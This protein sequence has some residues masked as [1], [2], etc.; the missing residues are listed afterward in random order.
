MLHI[1]LDVYIISEECAALIFR[2]EASQQK[3]FFY[4]EDRGSMFL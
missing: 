2:V 1:L 4:P 3:M